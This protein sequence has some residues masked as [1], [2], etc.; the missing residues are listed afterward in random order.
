MRNEHDGMNVDLILNSSVENHR[1]WKQTMLHKIIISWI[2]EIEGEE[3]RLTE[4]CFD[5]I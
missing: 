3:I 1:K 5:W 2:S 4:L